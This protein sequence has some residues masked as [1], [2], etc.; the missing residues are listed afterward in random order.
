MARR[1]AALRAIV[2]A[3]LGPREFSIAYEHFRAH[4]EQACAAHAACSVAEACE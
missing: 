1:L 4:I 2:T 3:E